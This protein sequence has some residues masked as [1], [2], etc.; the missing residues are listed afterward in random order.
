M[1]VQSNNGLLCV[2]KLSLERGRLSPSSSHSSV[3][4]SSSRQSVVS[5]EV[6]VEGGHS[7]VTLLHTQSPAQP[8]SSEPMELAFSPTDVHEHS[9]RNLVIGSSSASM[10]QPFSQNH[11]SH[12][13]SLGSHTT[14]SSSSCSSSSSSGPMLGSSSS[15]SSSSAI[16]RMASSNMVDEV[17]RMEVSPSPYSFSATTPLSIHSTQ[18]VKQPN[19]ALT[20]PSGKHMTLYKFSHM[21]I[22]CIQC[23][24]VLSYT[25]LWYTYIVRVCSLIFLCRSFTPHQ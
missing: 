19:S 6:G 4:M 24:C 20:I 15:S 23:S 7:E 25:L 22:S 14:A 3:K 9:S 13:A 17:A 2:P 1:L 8:P 11:S 10:V 12:S 18:R 5:Q 21:L 16:V